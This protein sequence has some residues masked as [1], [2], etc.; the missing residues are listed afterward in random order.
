MSNIKDEE[1]GLNSH[2]IEVMNGK[3]LVFIVDEVHR[4]TLGDM[5]ITIKDT[6]PN[7]IFFGFT[8]TPIHEENQKKTE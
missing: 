3:L 1:G 2:D 6:F 7:V 8:G 5:L 4:S